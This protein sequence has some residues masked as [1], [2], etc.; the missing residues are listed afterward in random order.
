MS[1]PTDFN[2][3]EH[4]QDMIRR[5]HNTAVNEWFKNQSDNDVSTPKAALKHACKIK[6][7]DTATMTAIRLWLFEVTTGHASSLHPPIYGIPALEYQ[8]EVTFSP[9]VRLF[10]KER[11]SSSV[12]RVNRVTG[13][14]SF[15]LMAESSESYTRAKAELLAKDIKREFCTPTLFEWGKGSKLY[16]YRDHN[17]GYDL[18]ILCK[19]KAEGER[20]AKT[21]LAVQGHTLESDYVTFSESEATY[22]SNPGTHRVYGQT[23]KKFVKR[24]T[25]DV[26]FRHAQL[27]LH[28]R[29][30]IINLVST[31]ESHLPGAIERV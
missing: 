15:R 30:K 5:H 1:L 17:K 16:Y 26:R 7:N 3:Y 4:L 20:V 18:R 29:T 2:E 9:Q 21:V 8:R 12:D 28:G 23:V 14:L 13:K 22:P 19:T 25:T 27:F 10:F 24:P 31:P 6:D 11:Y